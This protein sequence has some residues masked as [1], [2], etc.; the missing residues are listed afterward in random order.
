MA[1]IVTGVTSTMITSQGARREEIIGMRGI[2]MID[3]G[4][5][6]TGG[7]NIGRIVAVRTDIGAIG[8]GSDKEMMTVIAVEEGSIVILLLSRNLSPPQVH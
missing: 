7:T 8:I 5:V 4:R 2:E 1:V 3:T 6:E